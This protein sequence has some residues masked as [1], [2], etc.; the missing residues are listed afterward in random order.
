MNGAEHK[1][2]RHFITMF[3]MDETAATLKRC[4][5]FLNGYRIT[6]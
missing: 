3:G 4:V 1:V 2:S 5:Q 6:F